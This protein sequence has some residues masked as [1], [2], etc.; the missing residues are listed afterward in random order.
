M[1]DTERLREL[2]Q[3]ARAQP[4]IPAVASLAVTPVEYGR[5]EAE[6][7][8]GRLRTLL[9]PDTFAAFDF[10]IR[11]RR[12]GA[13]A[14]VW[15]VG[16]DLDMR[17]WR[18]TSAG[19]WRGMYFVPNEGLEFHTPGYEIESYHSADLALKGKE[20]A[21][22]TGDEPHSTTMLRYVPDGHPET[23]EARL[24]I[25]IDDWERDHPSQEDE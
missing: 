20:R 5:E 11:T 23:F 10:T 12:M 21:E 2:A 16:F 1:A 17:E 15:Y 18:V 6:E 4:A 9:Q 7:V 25:A 22:V 24:L 3:V 8:L 14:R 13:D 19:E